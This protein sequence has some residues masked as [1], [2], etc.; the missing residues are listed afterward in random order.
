MLSVAALA[1]VSAKDSTFR[2][3]A[4]VEILKWLKD[5]QGSPPSP[6][7]G[8]KVQF[9]RESQLITTLLEPQDSKENGAQTP[10]SALHT[11]ANVCIDAPRKPSL[12]P[13]IT[14]SALTRKVHLAH[15]LRV[16]H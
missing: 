7:K 3:D 4:T 5:R 6:G 8:G 11:V 12:L 9:A 13:H 16:I 15:S 1:Q 10:S 14:V 2:E